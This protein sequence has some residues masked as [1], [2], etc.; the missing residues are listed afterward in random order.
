MGTQGK[1][2][3]ASIIGREPENNKKV[4]LFTSLHHVLMLYYVPLGTPLIHYSNIGA[5][6]GHP[7]SW[8]FQF[9]N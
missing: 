3:W 6:H 9:V 4:I 7:M 2:L 1:V 5:L 8:L